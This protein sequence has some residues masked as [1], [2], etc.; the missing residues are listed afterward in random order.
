MKSYAKSVNSQI[1]QGSENSVKNIGVK[2]PL[3]S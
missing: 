1:N 2:T 3:K